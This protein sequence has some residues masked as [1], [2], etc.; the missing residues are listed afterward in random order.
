MVGGTPELSV[1]VWVGTADNTTA[2]YNS[3]GGTMFGAQAPAQ[4]WKGVLDGSLEGK[5]YGEFPNATPINWGVDPYSGGTYG[6]QKGYSSQDTSYNYSQPSQQRSAAPEPQ[7][8]AAS[9]P[10]PAPA[11]APA[12]PQAP[13]PAPEPPP[14][15]GEIL[16]ELVQ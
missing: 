5:D 13:E 2:I 12:P 11:P 1:A 7:A 3:Y 10:P 15:L 4:I 16:D 14:S 9:A 6:G 8:P